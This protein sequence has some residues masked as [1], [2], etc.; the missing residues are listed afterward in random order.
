MVFRDIGNVIVILMMYYDQSADIIS[1]VHK[2]PTLGQCVACLGLA[3]FVRGL[4]DID[5]PS[6]VQVQ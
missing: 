6:V 2:F 4:E 1:R 5:I 3:W